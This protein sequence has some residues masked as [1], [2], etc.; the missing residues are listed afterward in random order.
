MHWVLHF[1]VVVV[2]ILVGTGSLAFLALSFVFPEA[3]LFAVG[4]AGRLGVTLLGVT[5]FSVVVWSGVA[6]N[7]IVG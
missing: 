7:G 6:E 2:A 3:P 4:T 1:W 5:A